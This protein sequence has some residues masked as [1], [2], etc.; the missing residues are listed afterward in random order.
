MLSRVEPKWVWE[1]SRPHED[2]ATQ[3]PTGRVRRE[4]LLFWMPRVGEVRAE[5][6]IGEMEVIADLNQRVLTPR[7]VGGSGVRRGR[8]VGTSSRKLVVL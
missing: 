3:A 1:S 7:K 2:P 6:D 8:G 4:V 5:N